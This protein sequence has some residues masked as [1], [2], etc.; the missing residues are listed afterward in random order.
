MSINSVS[1]S[2]W[3]A[4]FVCWR[5]NRLLDNRLNAFVIQ[6]KLKLDN[7]RL[8][9]SWTGVWFPTSWSCRSQKRSVGTCDSILY[10]SLA[11]PWTAE[12][13]VDCNHSVR[14][15]VQSILL[16]SNYPKWVVD[17]YGADA[18]LML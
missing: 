8:A 17:C 13:G 14:G 6:T 5:D 15:I 3:V 1:M 2:H 7:S 11:R 10:F 16:K 9:P 18:V 4:V 12:T